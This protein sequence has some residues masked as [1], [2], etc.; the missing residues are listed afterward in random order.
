VLGPA[1]ALLQPHCQCKRSLPASDVRAASLSHRP[2]TACMHAGRVLASCLCAGS[3]CLLSLLSAHAGLLCSTPGGAHRG[4]CRQ[5]GRSSLRGVYSMCLLRLV[6]SGVLNASRTTV[7]LCGR[8]RHGETD[9]HTDRQTDRQ[10]PSE[11]GRRVVW[12]GELQ[13]HR[14][15][16]ITPH[17]AAGGCSCRDSC[18]SR[19]AVNMINT[20]KH[21]SLL[22]RSHA[23]YSQLTDSCVPGWPAVR[24]ARWRPCIMLVSS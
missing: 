20:H 15:G 19:L 21:T 4:V 2:A 24:P 7:L 6:L 14:S 23:P 13:L 16:E 5:Q 9:R 22:A 10:T 17:T 1:A 3:V 11:L 12:L 8:C 18:R